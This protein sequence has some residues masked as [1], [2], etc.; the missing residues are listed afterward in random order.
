M[1][2][3]QGE[4][5]ESLSL[6]PPPPC[7]ITRTC[8]SDPTPSPRV[9]AAAA[10][11]TAKTQRYTAP[12]TQLFRRQPI[13]TPDNTTPSPPQR[14]PRT[15]YVP[16]HAASSFARTASPLAWRRKER[17]AVEEKR[18]MVHEGEEPE[19][20][21]EEG[22]GI[23]GTEVEDKRK[24]IAGGGHG[25]IRPNRHG[26][27]D[28]DIFLAEADDRTLR[29]ATRPHLRPGPGPGPGNLATANRHHHNDS[30][31]CSTACS[32]CSRNNTCDDE[33]R[34]GIPRGEPSCFGLPHPPSRTVKRRQSGA[35][36]RCIGEYVRPSWPGELADTRR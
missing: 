15:P 24:D 14:P 9:S 26:P 31:D 2:E 22:K 35:L 8:P 3:L 13:A 30:A 34:A 27:T 5:E 28:Y 16:S 32:R 25:A 21:E 19:D 33:V 12:W 23:G 18:S 10:A 1:S 20:S 29:A 6:G 4:R 17:R 11:P 36:A 7:S